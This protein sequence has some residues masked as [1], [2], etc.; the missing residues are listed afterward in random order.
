M[1]KDTVDGKATARRSVLRRAAIGLAFVTPVVLGA[2]GL[3]GE[4]DPKCKNNPE[5]CLPFDLPKN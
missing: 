3:G 2:C 5:N 4:I 1:G